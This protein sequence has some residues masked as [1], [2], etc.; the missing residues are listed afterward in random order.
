MKRALVALTLGAALWVGP[1]VA[2]DA[3][4]DE[5]ATAERKDAL[6]HRHLWIAYGLAWALVF[7]FA[8]R[9]WRRSEATGRELEDLKA[10][11]GALE[12]KGEDS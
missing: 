5:V 6:R 11:L 12:A 7:G 2:A 4:R 1:A 9:A 10:R 8:Y 3:P